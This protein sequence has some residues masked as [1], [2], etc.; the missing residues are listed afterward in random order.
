MTKE[1]LQVGFWP[2]Q[3]KAWQSPRKIIAVV[4]GTGSGKT[5]FAPKWVHKKLLAKPDVRG[6]GVGTGYNTHVVRVMW[7]EIEK[8]LREVGEPY[9]P[10][11]RD[12]TITLRKNGSQLMF[13]SAENPLSL[14]G[15]HIEFAWM[16][17]A[18]MMPRIAWDV[19][20]RRTA[21][22]SGQILITTIPYFDGWLRGDVYD[23]WLAG[24]SS[25]EWIQCKTS[26]NKTYPPEEIERFRRTWSPAKFKRFFEGDWS[27]V[28]G[29]I[30]PDP[31][32]ADCVVD[33]FNV[34]D[35]WP[36]FSAHDFGMNAP[37]TG[38]WG[39]LSPDDVLYIVADYEHTGETIDYH[40]EQWRQSGL[41][42]VDC[43][44][45]D[46]ANPEVWLRATELGYP[47]L[48]ANNSVLAGLDAVYAR[49]VTGRLKIWRNCKTLIDHRRTYRWETAP[50]DDTIRMDR[51]KKPQP[52][53]HVCDA[54]R[55]LTMGVNDYGLSGIDP[56]VISRGR[57][58]A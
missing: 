38:V 44:W 35:E 53:E 31:S 54:L 50:K 36:A 20:Q 1:R 39:R 6:I 32:D 11:K 3:V 45:G 21:H 8:Y 42:S 26:D 9:V 12:Q 17:E 43:A 18:G 22:K 41:T 15:P 48:K 51:P 2:F 25:I 7:Y 29:L 49:F 56:M 46:P 19:V 55:Y 13:G 14:E 27:T 37:T 52:A 28:D 40:V 47:V 4:G 34:P 5:W 58:I 33:P 16:D 57:K 10:N 24:D 30:W 23:A